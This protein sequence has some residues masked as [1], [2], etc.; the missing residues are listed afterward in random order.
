[1]G[2]KRAPQV[3]PA[4]MNP[5]ANAGDRRDGVWSLGWEDPL[6]EGMATHSSVLAW[7]IPWT[8]EPGRLQSMRSQSWTWLKQHSTHQWKESQKQ[9]LTV[10]CFRQNVPRNSRVLPPI[11]PLVTGWEVSPLLGTFCRHHLQI[12]QVPKDF[13]LTYHICLT[14]RKKWRKGLRRRFL[15]DAFA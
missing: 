13:S 1:M 11:H 8:E 5:T 12:P 4:V 15:I 2:E 7:R 6:E 10:K 9:V 14:V 3:A